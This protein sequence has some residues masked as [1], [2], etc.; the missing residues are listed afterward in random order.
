ML[1]YSET[2]E[3]AYGVE[4]QMR[5]DANFEQRGEKIQVSWTM[6]YYRGGLLDT[7]TFHHYIT[8]TGKITRTIRTKESTSNPGVR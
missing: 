3:F 2:Q 5:P 8:K 7:W 4:K 1:F 6:R